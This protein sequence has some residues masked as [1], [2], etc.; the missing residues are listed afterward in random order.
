MRASPQT[1]KK[2]K[3]PNTPVKRVSFHIP[4]LDIHITYPSSYLRLQ[5]IVFSIHDFREFCLE[6]NKSSFVSFLIP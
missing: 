2:L 6:E 1:S 3:V 4:R 5:M